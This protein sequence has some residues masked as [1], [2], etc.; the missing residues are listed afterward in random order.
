MIFIIIRYN[1][2]P[3]RSRMNVED[4]KAE[5]IMGTIEPVTEMMMSTQPIH[6][7]DWYIFSII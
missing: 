1:Y 7:L 3:Q 6:S 2:P 4:G 5:G